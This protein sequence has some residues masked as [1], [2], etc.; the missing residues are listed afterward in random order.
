MMYR[1]V[2]SRNIYQSEVMVKP[3]VRSD[4]AE[5]IKCLDLVGSS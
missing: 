1:H 5:P 3:H 4:K 2:L